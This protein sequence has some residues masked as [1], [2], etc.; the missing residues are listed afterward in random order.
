MDVKMDVLEPRLLL[1][2][3]HRPLRQLHLEPTGDVEKIL[4]APLAILKADMEAA[5][6]LTGMLFISFN[7][8]LLSF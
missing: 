1:L 6:L 3:L 5:V 7:H 2:H 4:V 8:K